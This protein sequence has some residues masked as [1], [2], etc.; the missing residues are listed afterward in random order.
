MIVDEELSTPANVP[1]PL[2]PFPKSNE[3]GNR[4]N[5]L[6]AASTG[7]KSAC[8]FQRS[9]S[10]MFFTE[11]LIWCRHITFIFGSEFQST[12]CYCF[13]CPVLELQYPFSIVS[14]K[15]GSKDKVKEDRYV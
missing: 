9:F 3:L 4:R 7:R 10:G 1:L 2:W 8:D 15:L 14:Q 5:A 11:D 13:L 6:R 12:S